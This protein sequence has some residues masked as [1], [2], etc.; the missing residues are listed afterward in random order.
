ML[1]NSSS[2]LNKARLAW[3]HQ[4]LTNNAMQTD[5]KPSPQ[6]PQP[7]R[8]ADGTPADEALLV[9]RR[10]DDSLWITINRPQKHNPLSRAVL[11]AL[12]QALEACVHDAELKCV[13][14]RG[15]GERFFA[16]GGDL[17]DLNSVRDEAAVLKMSE[18]ACAALEAV[19]VCP[20]PVIA[21]LNGDAIGGAEL[22]MA[23]DMRVMS[24][25]ARLGYIQGRLAITSAWGGGPDLFRIVGPARATRMMG[26]A[27]MIDAQTA[28]QWGIA[29]AIVSDGV[30]GEDFASFMK[31]L[32]SM[33]P[34]VLRGIK[35]QAM[36]YR[37]G[38]D[39]AESRE[40][41]RKHLVTTWLHED[42]WAAAEKIMSK[43]S[44]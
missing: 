3:L 44:K 13:V 9:D 42:H 24:A 21:C 33:S 5:I 17:V 28:L 11:E 2:L 36:A 38:A 15:A 16:A 22:A 18:D 37:R 29:E 31:P 12:R 34:R 1:N 43:G 39:W 6:Q 7:N 14:I 32:L 26:R 19:R 8:A 30:D 40:V 25:H 27:E 20:V 10:E 35:A 4:C 23:A 41:E